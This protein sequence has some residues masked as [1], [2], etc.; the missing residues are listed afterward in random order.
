MFVS[1]KAADASRFR[2]GFPLR[3]GAEGAERTRE[4]FWKRH[5]RLEQREGRSPRPGAPMP[6]RGLRPS[7][8][9]EACRSC[10]V[11][12][13]PRVSPRGL[14]QET[15][16]SLK[17]V[18]QGERQ[19][20]KQMTTARGAQGTGRCCGGGSQEGVGPSAGRGGAAKAGQ[21]TGCVGW[22][23]EMSK[24][25]SEGGR[26]HSRPGQQHEL[27]GEAGRAPCAPC[28]PRDRPGPRASPCLPGPRAVQG[29]LVSCVPSR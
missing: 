3:L 9:S 2:A 27:V 25:R 26:R 8:G 7:L 13:A 29:Y 22:A 18:I 15:V 23:W 11:P 16:S 10:Y 17:L 12:A 28:P 5:R 14:W 4:A 6:R 21:R 1:G 20:S 19:T 24:C